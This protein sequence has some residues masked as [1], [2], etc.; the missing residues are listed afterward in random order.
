MRPYDAVELFDFDAGGCAFL[1]ACAQGR[2]L[3]DAAFA[4]LEARPQADLSRLMARLLNAGAF[5]GL[6]WSTPI[7]QKE[8]S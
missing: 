2:P 5:A 3:S 6:A 1:D 8:T 4:S 7:P